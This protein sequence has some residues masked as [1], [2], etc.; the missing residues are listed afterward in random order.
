MPKMSRKCLPGPP[1]RTPEKPP[2]SPATVQ[3]HSPRPFP[4]TLQ[5]LPRP[6]LSPRLFGDFSGVLWPE[7]PGEIFDQQ[8]LNPTPLNPT[9]AT[10]HKRKRKLRCSF[11]NVAL[12]K[13]HCNI[14]FSAAWNFYQ[15][16]RCRKRKTALQLRKSCVAGKWRFPAAFLRVSSPHV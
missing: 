15:K 11:R 10:C 13:L 8:V 3:K 6:R 4:E 9:P 16:L 7:G 5:R 1:A 2:T 14:R 12:Q